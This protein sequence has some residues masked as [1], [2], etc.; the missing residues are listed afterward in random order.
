M[1]LTARMLRERMK[2]G[3]IVRARAMM[4][5]GGGSGILYSDYRN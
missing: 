1:P 5:S 2:F 4:A 3:L